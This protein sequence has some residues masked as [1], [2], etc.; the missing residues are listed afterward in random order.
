MRK[1]SV[2]ASSLTVERELG[3]STEVVGE[4]LAVRLALYMDVGHAPSGASWSQCEGG[5][6]KSGGVLAAPPLTARVYSLLGVA[7]S[8]GRDHNSYP[9]G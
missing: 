3:H 4:S 8:P 6:N 9:G 7:R 2:E 5:P 1:I